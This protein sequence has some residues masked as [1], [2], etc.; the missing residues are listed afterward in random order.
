MVLWDG[1]GSSGR[2]TRV[3]PTIWRGWMAGIVWD[4][5][6]VARARRQSWGS[7]RWPWRGGSGA[8]GGRVIGGGGGLPT[9]IGRR[10][11]GAGWRGDSESSPIGGWVPTIAFLVFGSN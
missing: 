1:G 11:D 2:A 6:V 5:A 9:G 8:R 3:D 4:G 10:E 7:Q